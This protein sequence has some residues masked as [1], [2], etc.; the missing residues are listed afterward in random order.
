LLP[1]P[2][3]GTS[4]QIVMPLEVALPANLCTGLSDTISAH[5]PLDH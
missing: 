2:L 1:P 5:L 4:A 3:N